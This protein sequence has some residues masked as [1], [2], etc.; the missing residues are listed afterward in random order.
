MI[1]QMQEKDLEAILRIYNE[2]IIHT[3]AVYDYHPH[4]LHS[5]KAWYEQKMKDG[6]PV[7]VYE[8]E[9]RV[10]GFATFGPF[11]AWP[12]YK[13][14]VEHSIYV[15]SA[16]RKKGIGS[17]LLEKLIAIANE[18]GYMT[19]VAGIDAENEKS[20]DIHKK[21]GFVHAGTIKNAGYKFSRWLDLAFY[22][23]HLNG[24]E[25]PVDG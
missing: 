16:Y 10:A 9:N 3:T 20:I 25:N 6:Y 12:A 21:F 22:Q 18:R 4:S 7:L 13:Y 2:A 23:L 8:V 15:D 24:P 19:L 17:S 1:R 11:R 14:A 5:R